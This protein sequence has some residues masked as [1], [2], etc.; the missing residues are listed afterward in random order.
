MLNF[1]SNYVKPFYEI[2]D[3][4]SVVLAIIETCK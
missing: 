2:T 4:G 3:I 1:C